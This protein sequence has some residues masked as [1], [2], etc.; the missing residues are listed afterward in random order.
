MRLFRLAIGVFV[1]VQGFIEQDW[2][3]T[4]LGGFFSLTTIMNI[5]C[6]GA[7]NCYV[8]T[9]ENKNQTTTDVSYDEIR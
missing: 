7:G 3:L 4:G 1:L 2:L 5:G 8:P 9:Q 6:C